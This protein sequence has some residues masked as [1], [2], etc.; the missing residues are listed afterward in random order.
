LRTFVPGPGSLALI[1]QGPLAR[2]DRLAVAL[3]AVPEAVHGLDHVGGGSEADAQPAYVNVDRA[4]VDVAA[5]L[6][7]LLEQLLAR[8]HAARI[9]DQELQQLVLERPELRELAGDAD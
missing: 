1:I 3:G 8:E 2:P 7:D 4:S 6:P 9:R 5:H